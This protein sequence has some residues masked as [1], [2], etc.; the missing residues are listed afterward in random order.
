MTETVTYRVLCV[1][2]ESVIF[3]CNGI[4]EETN[5]AGVLLKMFYAC[6]YV[7]M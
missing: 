3:W 2:T 1:Q 6:V 5:G 7:L 4:L